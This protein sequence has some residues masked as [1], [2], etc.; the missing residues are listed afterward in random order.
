MALVALVHPEATLTVPALQAMNKCTLFQQKPALLTGPYK[1]GSTVLL[2]LFRQFVSALEGNA[3]EITSANFSGLTQLCEEFGFE[4]LRAKLSESPPPPGTAA[5]DAEARERITALKEKA[6]KRRRA[7]GLVQTPMK[8]PAW[9]APPVQPPV[10]A[11]SPSAPGRF[12]N[13]FG[14]SSDLR[15]VPRKTVQTA[16]AGQPRW[17]RRFPIP[18]TLRRPRKHTDPDFGHKGEHLRRIYSGGVGVAGVEW[19]VLERE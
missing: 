2:T 18:R 3:I 12:S 19:E 10:P 14:L 4:D 13:R 8:V 15:R 11:P 17:F 6:E 1:L 9:P 7:P 5:E 16:V